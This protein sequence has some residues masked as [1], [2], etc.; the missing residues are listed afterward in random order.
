MYRAP[1]KKTLWLLLI[2]FGLAEIYENPGILTQGPIAIIAQPLNLANVLLA[3]LILAT[4]A[5]FLSILGSALNFARHTS[6]GSR[7]SFQGSA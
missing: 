1:P 5:S 6:S 3:I 7:A 2:T 4:S